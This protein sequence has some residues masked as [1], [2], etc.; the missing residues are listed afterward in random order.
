[1]KVAVDARKAHD[2]GIGRY[3]RCLTA[4]MME[5]DPELRLALLMP[6]HL[7][8]WELP[9]D[10]ACRVDFGARL[11]SIEELW[12]TRGALRRI[13]PDLFH[14]PHYV[15]PFGVPCPSVVTIH[16]TIHVRFPAHLRNG[17]ARRY[18]RWMLRSAARRA[19]RVIT[20]SEA[21]RRDVLEHAGVAGDRIEAVPL[22]VGREFFGVPSADADAA[23]TRCGLSGAFLLYVG[24]LKPHKNP[25]GLLRAFRRAEIPAATLALAGERPDP[26]LQAVIDRERLGR[27][28]L[29]LGRVEDPE[30]RG[31]YAA[32]RL[33][34]MPSRWEGFGLPLLEAMAAGV[35]AVAAAVEPLREVGGDCPVYV[36]PDDTA[37]LAGAM[38]RLWD[39]EG[40]RSRRAGLGVARARGFTWERTA[41]RTL[42]AYRQVLDARLGRGSRPPSII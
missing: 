27:G 37:D 24:A 35:P 10:R 25:L 2:G 39:D 12:R 3:I 41:A 23:R 7:A 6:P 36:S 1:V 26:G 15:L 16:D 29:F 9:R 13:G 22:G 28:V 32:A 30:L 5:I 4:A 11:Y 20:V 17:I 8:L 34:V 42:A 21:S 33:F 18:A 19:D 40:E 38:R 31:L 14:E